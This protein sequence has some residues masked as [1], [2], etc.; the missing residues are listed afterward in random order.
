MDF[1]LFNL[2]Q[3]RDRTKSSREVVRDAIDQ[4]IAA[5]ELGFGRVWFAEHHFSNYS[6]CPAPL[7]MCGYAAG[8]TKKIRLGT[9]VVVPPLWSLPSSHR[10][11]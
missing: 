7:M 8:V 1:G 11:S 10:S 6:L 5:E 3:Q 2:M 9:A 4:T